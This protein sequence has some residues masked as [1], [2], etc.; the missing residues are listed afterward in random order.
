MV[1]V[2][3]AT[4]ARAMSG[5]GRSVPRPTESKVHALSKPAASIPRAAAARLE[6]RNGGPPPI[7]VGSESPNLAMSSGRDHSTMP[8]MRSRPDR[9]LVWICVLIAVNQLGV[10]GTV[11]VLALYA[12]SF[13]AGCR[14]NDGWL[15]PACSRWTAAAADTA[16][17]PYRGR[18]SVG[19]YFRHE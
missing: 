11:P 5:S 16:R 15:T 4:T 1:R 9:V 10:G 3:V 19:L 17:S 13:E 8:V 6:A 2:T 7:P 12:R 18:T 14:R